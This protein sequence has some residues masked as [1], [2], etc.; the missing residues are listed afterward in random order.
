MLSTAAELFS[1]FFQVG[2]FGFGGG[3]ALIPLMRT[4][5]LGHHWLTPSQFLAAIAIG[6]A[7][8]G[9]VAISA[10]FV[11]FRV[12]GLVGAFAATVGIFAPSVILTA[13]LMAAYRYVRHYPAFHTVLRAVL[14]AVV[15]LIAGV[16]WKLGSLA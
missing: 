14:A 15:G 8:P 4:V 10:T 2:L 7:T 1:S 16:T 12:A 13:A 9:P 3:F 5:V 6:Q 11:G